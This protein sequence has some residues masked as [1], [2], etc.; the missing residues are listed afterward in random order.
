MKNKIITISVFA[1]TLVACN[2]GGGSTDATPQPKAPSLP[3]GVSVKADYSAGTWESGDI[4]DARPFASTTRFVVTFTNPYDTSML[5]APS[6]I[7]A[8]SPDFTDGVL[9]S[10]GSVSYKGW[11]AGASLS[12]AASEENNCYDYSSGREKLKELA[13]HASCK[14]TYYMKDVSNYS[15]TE[16]LY[17]NIHYQYTNNSYSNVMKI[18]PAIPVKAGITYMNGLGYNFNNQNQG[19]Q[20]LANTESG[21]D[22]LYLTNYTNASQK[23]KVSYDQNGV[24]FLDY[25][26]SVVA[27]TNTGCTNGNVPLN[28]A[29]VYPYAPYEVVGMSFP[30][31]R[32]DLVYGLNE[33][34]YGK[35][36]N[37]GRFV[38]I[39]SSIT[40]VQP[41]GTILAYSLIEKAWGC[42]NN[43][44][45]NFRP[46]VF[47]ANYKFLP[48]SQMIVGYYQNYSHYK[49]TNWVRTGFGTSD[50][51]GVEGKL[52]A[53]N[54][55]T[56]I[57]TQDGGL[58]T[59]LV[60]K[61]VQYGNNL[62]TNDQTL[63]I[64]NNGV[65]GIY[66][67]QIGKAFSNPY[68]NLKFYKYPPRTN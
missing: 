60:G 63:Q 64:T 58:N 54:D 48:E 29:F 16:S 51:S 38:N 56:C 14:A 23:V 67:S 6:G 7:Y 22:Y 32:N 8:S 33:H 15:D 24:A 59:E 39:L 9:E 18:G 43:D 52:I 26:S 61:W 49:N 37:G 65:F 27:C 25:P 1:V 19:I 44:G 62:D 12:S 31:G 40:A 45:S 42:F 30:Y 17:I 57:L 10:D 66:V 3:M 35:D 55:G 68:Y 36:G 47:D 2:G 11:A 20:M 5:F 21:Q 46:V 34:L 50:D 13:P 4:I 53:S 41:D 28:V